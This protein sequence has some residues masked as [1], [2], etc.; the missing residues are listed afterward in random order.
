M[1]TL[2][3]MVTLRDDEVAF[4]NWKNV[5]PCDVAVVLGFVIVLNPEFVM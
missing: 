3:A 2:L 5:P 4:L 1:V